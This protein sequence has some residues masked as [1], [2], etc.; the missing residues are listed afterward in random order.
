MPWDWTKPEAW[1]AAGAVVA[2]AG[3]VAAVLVALWA[4]SRWRADRRAERRAEAAQ[5]AVRSVVG[6]AEVAHAM[7]YLPALLDL[8]IAR[9]AARGRIRSLQ[10]E[11]SAIELAHSKRDDEVA[12]WER[13]LVRA[14]ARASIHL[15]EPEL[16]PL[17]LML[18]E[19]QGIRKATREYTARVVYGIPEQAEIKEDIELKRPTKI[20]D[21]E[22]RALGVLVPIARYRGGWLEAVALWW[23][24]IIAESRA[25][26]ERDVRP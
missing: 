26:T 15:Q 17:R 6:S 14:Y 24:G 16:I 2:A 10:E 20:R 25:D 3:T 5:E 12:A 8:D 11:A 18:R 21:A 23:K 19:V 13:D 4:A 9:A 1:S 22:K 7:C